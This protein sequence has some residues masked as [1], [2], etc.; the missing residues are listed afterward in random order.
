MSKKTK[1]EAEEQEQVKTEAPAEETAK[2][3]A[4]P[5]TAAGAVAVAAV[6]CVGVVSLQGNS[7]PAAGAGDV[8][9][10]EQPSTEGVSMNYADNAF[11]NTSLEDMVA[12]PQETW[13]EKE[14]NGEVAC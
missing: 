12:I 5:F 10:A 9:V 1:P 2:A 6:A 7:Q 4:K 13:L 3:D 14:E 8:T 11:V